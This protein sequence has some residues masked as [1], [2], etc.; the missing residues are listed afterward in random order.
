MPGWVQFSAAPEV[1]IVTL[2]PPEPSGPGTPFPTLPLLP[3]PCPERPASLPPNTV[4]PAGC[5]LTWDKPARSP[6]L[7][8]LPTEGPPCRCP[9]HLSAPWSPRTT[10]PSGCVMCS[11]LF[12][13]A[14]GYLPCPEFGQ[15]ELFP[16]TCPF[17]A[18]TR[19]CRGRRTL[20]GPAPPAPRDS[21]PVTRMWTPQV[22]HSCWATFSHSVQD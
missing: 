6:P 19:M 7:S 17:P 12:S 11:D 22:L 1:E 18:G 10:V 20:A 9:A 2:F 8:Y 3:S 21:T 14:S 13:T 5:S 4:P 16:A 15:P